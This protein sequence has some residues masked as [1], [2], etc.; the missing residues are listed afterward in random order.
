MRVDGIYWM[1]S[2][3][4]NETG[5]LALEGNEITFTKYKNESHIRAGMYTKQQLMAEKFT[6]KIVNS[7]KKEKV[8]FTI[9]KSSITNL[10][11]QDMDP[12]TANGQTAYSG[13]VTFE[14]DGSNYKLMYYS[15][16]EGIKNEVLGLL[17]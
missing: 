3:I 6:K 1:K 2:K 4:K 8:L 14:A 15:T 11:N 13:I 7:F 16:D 12:A 10:E 17:K 5:Y 9:N